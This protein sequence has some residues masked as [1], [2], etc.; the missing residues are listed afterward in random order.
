MLGN[1]T[2]GSQFGQT[3]M[4]LGRHFQIFTRSLYLLFGDLSIVLF[5]LNHP[6]FT[7]YS[8]LSE[9]QLSIGLLITQLIK[10]MIDLK[11]HLALFDVLPI[12]HI[13]FMDFSW[14]PGTNI[15]DMCT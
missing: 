7:I 12:L 1:I 6:A 8:G 4:G 11:E 10:S 14:H 15:D 2:L 3:L 5:C 13:H 9:L